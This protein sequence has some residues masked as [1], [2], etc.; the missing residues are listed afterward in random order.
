MNIDTVVESYI[1]TRND[2]KALED[3][4]SEL[5]TFQ[6]RK[7]EWLMAQL[8]A[9]GVDSVKSQHGTVY[10]S[11]S[12]SVTVA[13][14]EAFFE[15]VKA[16]DAYHLLER[17]ASKAEVLNMMGDKDNGSRPNSPPPGINYV[18]VKK[19]CIRKA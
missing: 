1:K 9:L 10:T 6:A 14:S 2:I 19:V 8:A 7:D 17:R 11:V 12:E 15:Y 5:K 4:I 13:D 18:A 3:R 16:N